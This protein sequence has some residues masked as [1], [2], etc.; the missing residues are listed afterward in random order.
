MIEFDIRIDQ[1]RHQFSMR[2]SKRLLSIIKKIKALSDERERCTQSDFNSYSPMPTLNSRDQKWKE[3]Y[4]KLK[5][6]ERENGHTVVPLN[7]VVDGFRLG[8]WVNNQRSLEKQKKLPPYKKELL[9]RCKGWRWRVR[10]AFHSFEDWVDQLKKFVELN[11]HALVPIGFSHEGHRLGAW[12]SQV[13][14]KKN[15]SKLTPAQIL[16]LEAFPGWVW[17]VHKKL[18]WDEWIELLEKFKIENGHLCVPQRYVSGEAKLGIWVS[19][20][21]SRK[22]AGKLSKREIAQL[23]ALPGWKWKVPERKYS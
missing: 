16:T 15:K 18:T 5:N 14:V 2:R 21:K 13:R 4:K 22:K 3:N 12:V 17:T 8:Q 6:F 7:L 19:Q 11:G 10:P 23:E 20:Q 1:S 9:N